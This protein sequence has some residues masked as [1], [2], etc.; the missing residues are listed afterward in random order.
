MMKTIL[1]SLTQF[2]HLVIVLLS[3]LLLGGE[4]NGAISEEVVYFDLPEVLEPSPIPSPTAAL[5]ALPGYPNNANQLTLA[6]QLYVPDPLVSG[7]GP[8]PA[9]IILHGSGGLWSNDVIANGPIS[10]LEQ[11]GELLAGM[12]Y[13][14]LLPDSYNP[15]GIP[16]NFS[17][18]RPHHDPNT[19]DDLC[20]PNYERPK[21]V[22]A[23]LTYLDELANFDGENVALMGFSHGAQTGMNVVVD[24]SVDL[25]QYT[26][27]YID[28]MDGEEESTTK[29]VDSPVRIPDTLPFPKLGLF[30]YG[31]GSHYGYH[32]QAS[33]IAAGRYMIDRRMKALLFHG[34]DDYL[35]GVDD[36]TATPMTGNLF[37][38]KQALSSSMQAAALGVDDP[39]QRHYLLDLAEHSFDLAT[40]A[41]PQDWGTPNE[42]ADQLAKRL[43]RE[44]SLK[45]LEYCL[46]PSPAPT[47][48]QGLAPGDVELTVPT[49]N[50]R[51]NFQWRY[52]DDLINW[53]DLGADFDGDGAN[54]VTETTLGAGRRFFQLEYAPIEPPV[55]DYPDFFRD[56]SDF[57]Y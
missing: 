39:L 25:G 6:A 30:Y 42:S 31:G 35:L 41:D 13:L 2:R 4:A 5:A 45:W 50:A 16:G 32:G 12:G 48:I 34:T 10:H 40:I 54:V 15:R 1:L 36:P 14:V 47:L 18:R 9:V 56:Y 27:S 55:A 19:D 22:I 49:T 21:D 37:P 44:E 7:E 33:S 52:S 51:L 53:L 29:N 3:A 11:W 8:Y 23:A 26:V 17:S 46:K 20:S 43:C 38:I 24:V 57:S 28:L